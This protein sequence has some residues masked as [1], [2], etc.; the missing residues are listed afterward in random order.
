[1]REC[2]IVCAEAG[3]R[4]NRARW[5]IKT[6]LAQLPAE[7]SAERE[8]SGSGAVHT[9]CAGEALEGSCRDMEHGQRPS[10]RLILKVLPRQ[11]SVRSRPRHILTLLSRSSPGD[12]P[13]ACQQ[14]AHTESAPATALCHSD[15]Y[16]SSRL[17]YI[18]PHINSTVSK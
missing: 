16:V 11:R 8:A 3:G 13:G 9:A 7:G 2:Q 5:A 14:Q 18:P 1:M 6:I 15:G 12:R 4:R 10:Q 17:I